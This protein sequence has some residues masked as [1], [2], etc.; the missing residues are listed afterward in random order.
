[1][2]KFQRE[3]SENF[4]HNPQHNKRLKPRINSTL[5]YT[6]FLNAINFTRI[7]R[8]EKDPK[9]SLTKSFCWIFLQNIV[10]LEL[11][12]F[13]S[14]KTNLKAIFLQNHRT[15]SEFGMHIQWKPVCILSSQCQGQMSPLIRMTSGN[16]GFKFCEYR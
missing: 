11:K 13:K 7:F 1:M 3:I 14:A 2:K 9:N 6:S 12:S 15:G 8:I 16:C 10:F 5:Q 4:F